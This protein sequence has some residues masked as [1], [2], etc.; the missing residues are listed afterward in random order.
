MSKNFRTLFDSA[1][2]ISEQDSAHE[3]FLCMLS[4]QAPIYHFLQLQHR[5]DVHFPYECRCSYQDNII[6]N[7]FQ[8]ELYNFKAEDVMC[9]VKKS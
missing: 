6:F 1:L 3:L 4:T 9:Q 8:Y 5:I 7:E 2:A